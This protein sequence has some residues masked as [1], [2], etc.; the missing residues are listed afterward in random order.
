MCDLAH[1]GIKS[2]RGARLSGS[3]AVRNCPDAPA[4]FD[5]A[6]TDSPP[7]SL[8]GAVPATPKEFQGSQ[9]EDGEAQGRA[10]AQ[11]CHYVNGLIG[12]GAESRSE[13]QTSGKEARPHGR[14]HRAS[15]ET[16]IRSYAIP[17]PEIDGP[18]SSFADPCS[19]RS[20]FLLRFRPI[21]A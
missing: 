14:R 20:D 5:A 19:G 10:E 2:R 12:A 16:D 17:A 7:I 1:L 4:G 9:E 13:A 15:G 6:S 21:L 8:G 11:D 3:S 18:C